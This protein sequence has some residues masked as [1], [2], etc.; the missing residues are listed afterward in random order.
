MTFGKPFKMRQPRHET[1]RQRALRE[2]RE[3]EKVPEDQLTEE[4]QA[5]VAAYADYENNAYDRANDR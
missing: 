3:L 1:R 5:T 4:E 2:A